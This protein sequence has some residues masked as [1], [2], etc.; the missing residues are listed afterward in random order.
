MAISSSLSVTLYARRSASEKSARTP[1]PRGVRYLRARPTRGGVPTMLT[2]LGRPHRFCDRL[3]RRDFLRVG[4]LALVGLSLPQLP[5]EETQSPAG[6][7]S[8][9]SVIMVFLSGG[10]PHQDM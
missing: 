6:R 2:L 5:R 3:S 1:R 7:R 9:K 10:P 4:G 8:H